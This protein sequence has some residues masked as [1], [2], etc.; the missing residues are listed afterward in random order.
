MSTANRPDDQDRPA[1]R[2]S[3]V[4]V[5]CFL[6]LSACGW[7]PLYSRPS[8]DPKSGGVTATMASVAID[9]ITTRTSL[10]PLTGGQKFAYDARAAQILHNSLRDAFNPYGQPSQPTYHLMVELTEALTRAASLGNGDST[11][12][13][14]ALTAKYELLNEKGQAVLQDRARVITSYDILN[15]PFSDLQSHNDALQRGTEQ[16]S[17]MIQTRLAVFLRK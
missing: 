6:A 17:Q 13:D 3:R 11:R 2:L 12:D 16:L 4:L 1:A 10:D 14:L 9:P 15:E 5:F 8:P 7:Q